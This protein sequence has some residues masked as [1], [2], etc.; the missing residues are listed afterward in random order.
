MSDHLIAAAAIEDQRAG[1]V[2]LYDFITPQW[3]RC[4]GWFS[5]P[6][7][8]DIAQMLREGRIQEALGVA[9]QEGQRCG[10]LA[11]FRDPLRH[12]TLGEVEGTDDA[13]PVPDL[14]A[15]RSRASDAASANV[16]VRSEI[17]RA[18]GA[19]GKG[20]S[21]DAIKARLCY[22]EDLHRQAKAKDIHR[23]F[24]ENA[25]PKWWPRKPRKK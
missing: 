25:I 14:Q 5:E 12:T 8:P 21:F 15:S 23:R 19:A 13:P 3:S 9:F 7:M 4:A 6:G 1:R 11:A 10:E 22:R 16:L 2:V 20:A 24:M 18:T 17:E